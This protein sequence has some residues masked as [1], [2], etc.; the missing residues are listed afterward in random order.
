MIYI[1]SLHYVLKWYIYKKEL[2]YCR[3]TTVETALIDISGVWMCMDSRW[4]R[5]ALPTRKKFN[6]K[7]FL[8]FF[9]TLFFPS[10]QCL[11]TRHPESRSDCLSPLWTGKCKLYVCIF[12]ARGSLRLNQGQLQLGLVGFAQLFF[13]VSFLLWI[14]YAVL[15]LHIPFQLYSFVYMAV[16][17]V[18]TMSSLMVI[19]QRNL[20]CRLTLCTRICKLNW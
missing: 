4:W 8:H 6:W 2:Q 17:D 16:Y 7:S 12:R 11:L 1:D 20:C 13:V 3:Y 15:N 18:T 9:P 5:L 10:L 14:D 19:S